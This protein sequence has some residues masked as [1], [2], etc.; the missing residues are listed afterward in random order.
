M[1]ILEVNG[2]DFEGKCNFRFDKFADKKYNE[3]DKNGNQA[4]GF[5][6][7]YT[8]LLQFSNKHLVYFWDCALEYKGKEKPSILEIEEALDARFEKDGGTEE[9]FKEAFQLIDE[10]AFF[11]KQARNFW[12][13]L[14]IMKESGKDDEEKMTNLKVYNRLKAAQ[15]ELTE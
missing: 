12:K 9:A 14:E 15:K 11:G 2:K 7:I 5:H 1:A 4:G 6:N 3:E 8:G 13:D 10:S